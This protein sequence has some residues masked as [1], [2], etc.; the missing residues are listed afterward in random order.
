MKKS[1]KRSALAFAKC[2]FMI[3]I[4]FS[5]SKDPVKQDTTSIEGLWIGY[6]TVDGNPGMGSQYFSFAIKPDGTLINDTQGDGQQHL[7]IGAWSL[8]G[9]AFSASATCVYGLPSNI[10]IVETH[11]ATFNKANGT[12]SNGVWKNTPPLTGSGTFTIMKVK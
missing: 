10:G 1:L 2:F 4:L 6:Y 8:N 5:C 11:T 7:N 9:D 3:A 12:F